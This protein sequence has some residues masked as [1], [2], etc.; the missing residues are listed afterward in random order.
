MYVDDG[1]FFFDEDPGD[2]TFCC[3]EMVILNVNLYNINIDNNSDED[4]PDTTIL[5]RLLAWNS[6]F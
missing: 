6:T 5:I 4:D 2:V 3:N 1:L